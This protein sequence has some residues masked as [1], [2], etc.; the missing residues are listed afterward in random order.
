MTE[1]DSKVAKKPKF[2]KERN[3][4]ECVHSLNDK[5]F[6]LFMIATLKRNNRIKR[7]TKPTKDVQ[8]KKAEKIP[9][10]QDLIY[11][12]VHCLRDAIISS[13]DKI[14]MKIHAYQSDPFSMR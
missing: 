3:H 12:V 13:F 11:L 10:H 7:T 6:K 14:S 1:L 5:Q 4:G 8:S 2:K 9:C